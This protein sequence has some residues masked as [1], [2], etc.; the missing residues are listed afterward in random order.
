MHSKIDE[1]GIAK[2]LKKF[3]NGTRVCVTLIKSG[4]PVRFENHVF[5]V[6]D[7]NQLPEEFKHLIGVKLRKD[8][9]TEFGLWKNRVIFFDP[10]KEEW[11]GYSCT[12]ANKSKKLFMVEIVGLIWNYR[13][14]FE[15]STWIPGSIWHDKPITFEHDKSADMD[16]FGISIS[17]YNVRSILFKKLHNNEWTDSTYTKTSIMGVKGKKLIHLL[18]K[19]IKIGNP[20]FT[21][22][23]ISVIR[24]YLWQASTLNGGLL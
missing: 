13:D 4:E 1:D 9:G 22:D 3:L 5:N 11:I 15:P 6:I 14:F 16:K 18:T 19:E 12:D 10:D 17:G 2:D 23:E 7:H 8:V 20:V 21:F 24:S